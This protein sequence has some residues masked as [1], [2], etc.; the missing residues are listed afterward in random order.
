MVILHSILSMH[1][2]ASRDGMAFSQVLLSKS[3]R[4][5][6]QG[7]TAR[8]ETDAELA[9]QLSN[10]WW[11][12]RSLTGGA[13]YFDWQTSGWLAGGERCSRRRPWRAVH[14]VPCRAVRRRSVRLGLQARQ[15]A[16]LPVVAGLGRLLSVSGVGPKHGRGLGDSGRRLRPHGGFLSS[17][18]FSAHLPRSNKTGALNFRMEFGGRMTRKN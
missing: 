2:T 7:T 9:V 8:H 5:H 11:R 14:A 6:I 17:A 4:E 18:R 12:A 10:E 15:Q 3:W 13:Q 16:C 1:A